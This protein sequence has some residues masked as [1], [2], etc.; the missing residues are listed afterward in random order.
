MKN[1]GKNKSV[2]LIILFSEYWPQ[3]TA[4]FYSILF[5]TSICQF[6]SSKCSPVMSDEVGEHLTRDQRPFLHPDP[7]DS[8]L[9][10]GASIYQSVMFDITSV[11]SRM[12]WD[13]AREP[14]HLRVFTKQAN[15]SWRACFAMRTPPR[16]V[17][18]KGERMQSEVKCPWSSRASGCVT[19]CPR[20]PSAQMRWHTAGL[21]AYANMRF[22]Q[23]AFS[24]W[25]YA[26]SG[27]T[28]SKSFWWRHTGPIGLGSQKW[29]FSWQP[30]LW[31]GISFLREGAPFG[32][33]IQTC[34]ISTCG[35]WTGRGGSRWATIQ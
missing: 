14:Y 26:R 24:H 33:C 25:P 32:T 30:P 13:L 19:P 3:L 7:S 15:D 27:R 18:I 28:R 10:V 1:G 21:G 9:N 34:G 12:G 6:N 2:V 5:E 4:P 17:G 20:G 11:W 35:P 23:W 29:C 16:S 31:G 8:Q 22:P